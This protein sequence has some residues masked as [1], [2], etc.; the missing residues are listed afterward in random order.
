MNM[1]FKR[2]RGLLFLTAFVFITLIAAAGSQPIIAY[3][4]G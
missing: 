4:I 3:T 2:N 1:R